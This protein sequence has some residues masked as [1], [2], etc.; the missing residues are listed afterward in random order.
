MVIPRK[1]LIN[2]GVGFIS[3]SLISAS[4]VYIFLKKK[5]N[6]DLNSY[7]EDFRKLVL[8]SIEAELEEDSELNVT[9]EEK[10]APKV[11]AQSLAEAD[12]AKESFRRE[13]VDYTKFT[14]SEKVIKPEDVA[15]VVSLSDTVI[16]K[17]AGIDEES[18]IGNDIIKQ[19]SNFVENDDD[20][21][22]EEELEEDVEAYD[23]EEKKES[24]VHMINQVSYDSSYLYH[25]KLCLVWYTEEG[26][27][28]DDM[29]N[30][31]DRP[32][33]LIGEEALNLLKSVDYVND[34]YVRN[35]DNGAD[36][37]IV[38]HEGSYARDVLGDFAPEEGDRL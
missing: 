23:P 18:G 1:E 14:D 31:V 2:V 11:T 15:S 20:R 10:E 29:D 19:M 24:G 38:R 9:E 5:F 22:D 4:V 7:I 16:G 25:D 27:L 32:E 21:M 30:V 36:F 37:E 3:G 12:K 17:R 6:K 34:L 28:C 33:Q 13:A 8:N 35:F 26:I